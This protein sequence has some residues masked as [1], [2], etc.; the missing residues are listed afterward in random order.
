MMSIKDAA[1][2]SV[3]E[4]APFLFFKGFVCDMRI[5]HIRKLKSV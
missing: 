4:A 1:H 5:W 2:L 3:G